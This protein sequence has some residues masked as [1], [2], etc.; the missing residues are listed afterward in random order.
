MNAKLPTAQ[1]EWND[2]IVSEIH[3]IRQNLVE[4]YQGD[5][6]AYSQAVTTNALALGFKFTTLK[7]MPT[8]PTAT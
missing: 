8:I 2:P 5:L 1:A 6:H 7:P 4:K 3:A